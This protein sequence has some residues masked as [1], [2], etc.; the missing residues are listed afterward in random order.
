M[1]S[2]YKSRTGH[3]PPGSGDPEVPLGKILVWAIATSVVSAAVEVIIIRVVEN[4]G[5]NSADQAI[6]SGTSS[7]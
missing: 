1:T 4:I 2:A 6:T 5:E 7:D 3:Q